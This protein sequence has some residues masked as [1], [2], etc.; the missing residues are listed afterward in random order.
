MAT[1]D[2]EIEALYQLPVS[3]FTAA[4]NALAKR[5]G[6]R[7]NEVKGLVKPN[8]A[9]WA[10]NQLYWHHRPVFDALVKAS[11][12]SRAA[13]VRQLA[14]EK[15]NL[16]A[17]DLRHQAALAKALEVARGYLA[18][19]GDAGSP[20]T[21]TAVTHTLEAVPSPDV[22]GRLHRPIERVG[23]SMLADYVASQ[24]IR[25]PDRPPAQVVVMKRPAPAGD[26]P[27]T[28]RES[29][30][31]GTA[32]NEPRTARQTDV[33]RQRERDRL[34]KTLATA[35]A[36]ER[37]SAASLSRVERDVER[38]REQVEKLHASWEK[39]RAALARHERDADEARRAAEDARVA[40]ADI[41]QQL[42]E[43]D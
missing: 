36:Q 30:E 3:E 2:G 18:A 31:S 29:T 28:T 24:G 27:A 12:T 38:A 20:A 4:R 17:A 7:A 11:E 8:A 6:G 39:A 9:A 15:V 23:F 5:A 42:S 34:K 14:G 13:H 43:I 40:R 1:L 10:V 22:H 25:L 16:E 35:R 32:R 19:S 41:E 21:I 33:T 37:E 26:E